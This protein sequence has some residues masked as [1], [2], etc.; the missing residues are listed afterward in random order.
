MQGPDLVT[1]EADGSW[2]AETS[3][4]QLSCDVRS[5]QEQITDP[6]CPDD[7]KVGEA[8]SFHCPEGQKSAKTEVKCINVDNQAYPS[9]HK[10]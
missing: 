10:K 3:C 4:I 7:L 5:L 1:C 8:C 6:N 2:S 9:D